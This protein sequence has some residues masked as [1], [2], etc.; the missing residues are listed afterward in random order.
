MDGR[1]ILTGNRNLGCRCIMR[2]VE[3]CSVYTGHMSPGVA[4]VAVAAA[5]PS[6][7]SRTAACSKT[8]PEPR[9]AVN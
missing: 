2:H 1:R 4:D 8:L 5:L 6:L 7:E 9:L 3:R